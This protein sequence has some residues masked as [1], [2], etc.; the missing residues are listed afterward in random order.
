MT[1]RYCY[2]RPPQRSYHPNYHPA[3]SNP[4]AREPPPAP[5]SRQQLEQ[6]D[7]WGSPPRSSY[8]NSAHVPYYPSPAPTY[9]DSRSPPDPYSYRDSLPPSHDE[10]G[11]S[12]QYSAPRWSGGY[13]QEP[14]YPSP[15][16]RSPPR[17]M[18]AER[19]APP[20]GAHCSPPSARQQPYTD[21]DAPAEKVKVKYTL[22][23]SPA[24]QPRPPPR[25]VSLLSGIAELG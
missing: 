19:Y 2:S 15:A 24:P 12:G 6:D 20:R 17:R 11:R 14:Y 18:S 5:A 22:K 25:T 21:W 4:A 13:S 9:H 8:S 3:P 23:P 10:Y 16:P 7:G 1:P